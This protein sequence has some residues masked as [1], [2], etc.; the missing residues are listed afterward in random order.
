MVKPDDGHQGVYV[1]IFAIILSAKMNLIRKFGLILLLAIISIP[2]VSQK[3]IIRGTVIEDETGEPLFGVTAIVKGTT[4]G[5]TTDFD[6]K[7]EIRVEPGSYDLAISFVSF[8]TVTISAVQV[9][10]DDVTVI[11]QI[12]MKEDVQ[13]LE[14]IVI[15]AEALKNTEEALITVKKK[16][17]NLLDGISAAGFRKIGDSDAASAAKRIT[18]V[19]VQGGKYV[20]V[21][22]LGDRYTKSILNGV[23]VPGLDPDRNTLQMDI[24]P[25]NVIDN[26]V[27]VK[28][29]TADLP[30]DFTG[31]VVNIETKDFPEEKTLRLSMSGSFNPD[32]H[33][34]SNYLDY[35]GS[36][37]DWL[38]FDNG[39][40]DIPF[41]VNSIPVDRRG[42]PRIPLVLDQNGSQGQVVFNNLRAFDP[43]LAAMR[44]NSGMDY[45]LGVSLGNQ[46]SKGKNTFGYSFGLTYKNT[47]EFYEEAEYGRYGMNADPSVTELET[48]EFQLGAQ[49]VNNVLVGGLA[50]FAL[51][52]DRSKFK[53]SVLHL[54]NG[55]SKAGIFDFTGSDQG[56]DF[57]RFQHNLEYSERTLS[58]VLFMGEHFN[59]DGS[60]NIFWKVSP[61]LSKIND[62]DIRFTPYEVRGP[63][64][65]S[66]TSEAGFPERI[67]RSLEEVNLA[68]I[69]GATK[70]YDFNGEQGKF[71]FGGGHTFKE[72][73]YLIQNFQIIVD[74]TI[75]LTGDPDEIFA[76]E[77]LWPAGGNRIRGN[78]YNPDF[79]PNNPNEFNATINNSA[80][81]ISN[82]FNPFARLKMIVG[83]RMEMYVQNYSGTNRLGD[84]VLN[85]S[86]VIDDLNFFPTANLIYA[87]SETQNLRFSYSKTIARP[88]FKEAS[89]AAIIDPL[90]GR[91]F[92]GSFAP[93]INVATGETIWDGNIQ[94]TTIDNFDL[95]WE[96]FQARGQMIS[97][98]AF[99][100]G[101]Q[102]PIEIVQY[103][104]APNSFQPRNVGNGRVL[105]TEIEVRQ[106]LGNLL[107]AL[108]NIL[109]TGNVTI[110][111]S[112]IDMSATELQS[113]IDNARTD[114]L[115][116]STRDMA[117]QAPYIINS[118]FAYQGL[119]N[120]LE[121]GLYYNVQGETLTF[122]GIADR[123]DV[124]SVPFHSV[125]FTANKRFGEDQKIQL[126]LKIS[127]LLGDQRQLVFKSFGAEERFFTNLNP[128][129]SFKLSFRY[130]LF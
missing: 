82:E 12:R 75:D 5:A 76:E 19:S 52:R 38:G 49:G 106:S 2:A 68:G 77:N 93:D 130:S 78:Y 95:R 61:T 108:E 9:N 96:I 129:T 83:L 17:P 115:I 118:G 73:D 50:G 72:R 3:G 16:S 30:A 10:A 101:F 103:V 84:I 48:R 46:F 22:G 92:I 89:Y 98:S 63:G 94:S 104:Q 67:W 69:V 8:Q 87:L 121:A 54:Q 114:Q 41:D 80:A 35:E 20:F 21:R 47:T 7:F 58:N 74:P 64:D 24:F 127:N 42:R 29:F 59:G 15:T 13:Q 70:E 125:N 51:K 107:P 11:G 117:G 120:G 71:K 113:R 112:R 91:T 56:A 99:Y 23:D 39:A 100:K 40:R 57:I 31:G 66:I 110:T 62:P 14:E 25:T 97:V 122:V 85:D 126:G 105:G 90:T 119:E 123:P 81:Y 27:V 18:G 53:M 116:E 44:Q 88:S 102:N 36:S 60:W 65:F 43:T 26:I 109:F 33:F 124:Y 86:T 1:I 55:E 79:L 111:Q 6:G 4:T 45:S 37:T 128:G 28:S 34:N 32:M